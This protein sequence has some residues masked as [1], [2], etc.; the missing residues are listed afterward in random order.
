MSGKRT[1]FRE[2]VEGGR[3]AVADIMG[4]RTLRI[5][6]SARKAIASL[7]LLQ[8]ISNMNEILQWKWGAVATSLDSIERLK[9]KNLKM[10]ARVAMALHMGHTRP[11]VGLSVGP[12]LTLGRL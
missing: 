5:G 2:V 7:G 10:P 9:P 6:R 1:V 8:A 3:D 12:S 4:M 11:L